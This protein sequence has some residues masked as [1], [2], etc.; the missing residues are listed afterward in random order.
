MRA[1][2]HVQGKWEFFRM[3]RHVKWETWIVHKCR[4]VP[5]TKYY[6]MVDIPNKCCP[7]CKSPIPREIFEGWKQQNSHMTKYFQRNP[8]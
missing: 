3:D 7:T 5:G 4:K 1:P 8:K 2:L 6:F